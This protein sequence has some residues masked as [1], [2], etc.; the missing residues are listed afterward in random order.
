MI[1][2]PPNS[3]S[4][5]MGI[6]SVKVLRS[7]MGRSDGRGI[8]QGSGN[9]GRAS[10]TCVP[11]HARTRRKHAG[12]ASCSG[13]TSGWEGAASLGSYREPVLLYSNTLSLLSS[14]QLP[15]LHP[16]IDMRPGTGECLARMWWP[17]AG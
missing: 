1:V 12:G 10:K 9:E 2:I 5:E 3:V 15:F 6:L 14:L 4:S 7:G 13:S 11:E 16:G 17:T 8:P